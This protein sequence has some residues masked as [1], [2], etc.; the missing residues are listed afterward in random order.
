MPPPLAQIAAC[1]HLAPTYFHRVFR[2]LFHTTPL[3]YM[4]RRRLDSARQLLS[5][6]SLPVKEIAYRVG[7]DNEFYFS[8]IF[9]KHFG[10]SPKDFQDNFTRHI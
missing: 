1:S 4:T 6:T 5:S 2:D 8:R 9:R 10:L 7:Y 3:T